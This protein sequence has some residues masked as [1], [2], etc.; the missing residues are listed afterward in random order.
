[1]SADGIAA[2]AALLDGLA[3]TASRNAKLT[4]IGD[5]MRRTPDPARGY[6]LAALTGGLDLAGA[7]PATIRALAAE[8]TD[9]EL[10]AMSYDY[11]GDLAETTAL[12][13]PDILVNAPPPSLTEA[14]EELSSANRARTAALLA[15][16]LDRLD[17]DGRWALLKLATGGLRV[18]VSA[19]LAKVALARA[20]D[21]DVAD[22]EEIWHSLNPPYDALFAWLD[23]R[24]GRPDPG[25]GAGFRPVMLAN[26]LEDSQLAK[27]DPAGYAA[28]W[29]WDGIRVQAAARGGER[30][31]YSRT[32]DDIGQSFPDVIAGFDFDGVVDGELLIRR[33]GET[34][35]H[36]AVAPF[37][38]LQK[39]LGR[40]RPDRKLLQA[41]PAFVRV[42]DILFDGER[43]LRALSFAER[44]RR[45]EAWAEGAPPVFDLSPLV[46]FASWADLQEIRGAARAAGIEGL[47]LKRLDAPYSAGRPQGQWFKWKRDPL[48]LDLVV[49]YAQ[50]GHGRRSSFYSDYTFGAWTTA[51][52]LA[53]VGKA[54][55]GYTDAELAKLDKWVR[56]NTTDRFG[57]VR[58]VA[59]GLVFEVAFDTAQR[60]T[61]HKSGVALRFPRIKRIRWDKPAEEAETLENVLK[62]AEG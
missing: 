51:G 47:M 31:L 25:A 26:P 7:K 32:G 19:R 60:S 56:Q 36:A 30:R 17:A 10:F 8:R 46:S 53:P 44:R 12:I 23:G 21:Q 16:W 33:E 13:W 40:K 59:P 55:S 15:A 24:A 18:G 2:F 27:L 61:R 3:F 5:Y 62:L 54:Y 48:T 9:P 58:A 4:L 50:R 35:G 43:D 28:E 39:R 37:A 42:Y 29:K 34:E 6:A 22:I 1:M 38:Q 49:M 41:S 52:E 11:V 20:F 45:L 14:V 57:P